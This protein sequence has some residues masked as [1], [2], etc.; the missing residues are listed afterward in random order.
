M[1][2]INLHCRILWDSRT[3]FMTNQKHIKKWLHFQSYFS[4]NRKLLLDWS[5]MRKKSLMRIRQECRGGVISTRLDIKWM[6][7]ALLWQ[8]KDLKSRTRTTNSHQ[9]SNSATGRS[10]NSVQW[11]C[12]SPEIVMFAADRSSILK[13]RW[14][15]E[16]KF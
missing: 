1:K 2:L 10:K 4:R 3:R 8:C 9:K 13:S 15:F 5:I 12:Y 16:Q 11:S 7:F 6:R 14:N